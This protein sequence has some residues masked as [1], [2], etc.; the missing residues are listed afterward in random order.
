VHED[1]SWQG[2]HL[3]F[4]LQTAEWCRE[5]KP[6]VVALKLGAVVVPVDMLV[7][8]S[9]SLVCNQLLPIHH[10]ICKSSAF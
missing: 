4:V 5:N 8:L 3:C 1:A 6:I 10:N 9:E 2:K 7:F